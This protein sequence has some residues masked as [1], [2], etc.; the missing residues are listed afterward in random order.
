MRRRGG[1]FLLKDDFLATFIKTRS[2]IKKIYSLLALKLSGLSVNIKASLSAELTSHGN[3]DRDGTWLRPKLQLNIN[4]TQVVRI[5]SS[6]WAVF[7]VSLLDS[8]KFHDAR[9]RSHFIQSASAR[10]RGP[11]FIARLPSPGSLPVTLPVTF[12][13][14]RSADSAR[15]GRHRRRRTLLLLLGQS[16]LLFG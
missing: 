5:A 4:R 15:R 2:Y 11:R 10:T 3:V 12:P 13:I 7:F 9:G 1:W 8:Q 14:T 6:S 16:L